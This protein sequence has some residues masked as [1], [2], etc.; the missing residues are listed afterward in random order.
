MTAQPRSRGCVAR[1]TVVWA[2]DDAIGQ[3]EAKRTAVVVAVKAARARYAVVSSLVWPLIAQWDALVKERAREGFLVEVGVDA[4]PLREA[5][6]STVTLP[7][8]P[9]S[10]RAAVR[11]VLAAAPGA[12]ADE[13][14]LTGL[15]VAELAAS[16]PSPALTERVLQD[17][18]M[19]WLG[20]RVLELEVPVEQDVVPVASGPVEPDIVSGD[21]GPAG[22]THTVLD[23]ADD[24]R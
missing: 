1:H 8:F 24:T 5:H 4:A 15:S 13:L 14:D 22:V 16:Y 7:K 20:K 3:V 9:E 18:G 2:D 12:G 21:V 23:D 19:L 10:S 6:R 17:L 11:E